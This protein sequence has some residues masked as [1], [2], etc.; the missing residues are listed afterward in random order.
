MGPLFQLEDDLIILFLVSEIAFLSDFIS[1]LLQLNQMIASEGFYL[2]LE[3]S[4]GDLGLIN[5]FGDVL[6][7]LDV[8]NSQEPFQNIGNHFFGGYG[9]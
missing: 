6:H 5:I 3:Q 8:V 7:E 4:I 9:L 2:L 1:E